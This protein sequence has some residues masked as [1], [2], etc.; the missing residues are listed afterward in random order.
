MKYLFWLLPKGLDGCAF[1]GRF[2]MSIVAKGYGIIPRPGPLKLIY[3]INF[4]KKSNKLSQSG[5]DFS[6]FSLKFLVDHQ[7]EK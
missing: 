7:E 2:E 6:G 5:M 4:S 1:T 3:F